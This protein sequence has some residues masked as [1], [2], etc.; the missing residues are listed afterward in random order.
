MM[1]HKWYADCNIAAIRQVLLIAA[2][3]K[4][5]AAAACFVRCL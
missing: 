4:Q 3:A 5:A 2:E 1:G